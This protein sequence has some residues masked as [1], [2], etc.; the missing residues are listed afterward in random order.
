[1]K[2]GFSTQNPI[3]RS[4]CISTPLCPPVLLKNSSH[5]SHHSTGG[6]FSMP[7]S[8]LDNCMS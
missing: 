8:C 3:S 4:Q 7:H 2:M 5:T 1:M 6:C